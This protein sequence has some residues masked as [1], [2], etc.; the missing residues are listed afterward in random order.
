MAKFFGKIGFVSTKETVP[1]VWEEVPQEREYYGDIVR[2]GYR[3]E[4]AESVN[5]EFIVNNY[6]SIVA[7]EFAYKNIQ[8]MRWV[9]FMDTKW[10]I[11]SA[12]LEYPRIKLTLGKVYNG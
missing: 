5:K 1:G 10:E 12:E 2:V 8:Y 9:E 11:V 7:D 6:I 3:L 4:N